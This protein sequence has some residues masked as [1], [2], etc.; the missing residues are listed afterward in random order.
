V[1]SIK[2]SVYPLFDATL[3]QAARDWKFRPASK[4]G[5]PVSYRTFIEVKLVP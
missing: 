1:A 2:K 4:Q 5:Q 3:V